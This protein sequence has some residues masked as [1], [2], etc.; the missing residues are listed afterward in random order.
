MP[1][2]YRSNAKNCQRHPLKTARR[3]M[4]PVG[5]HATRRLFSKFDVEVYINR[6]KIRRCPV[7]E[8]PLSKITNRKTHNY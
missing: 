7:V 5:N 8:S 4:F 1:S 2:F 3:P 6:V